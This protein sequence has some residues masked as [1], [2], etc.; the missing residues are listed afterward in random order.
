MAARKEIL[1]FI[2]QEQT[3]TPPKWQEVEAYALRILEA[4]NERRADTLTLQNDLFELVASCKMCEQRGIKDATPNFEVAVMLLLQTALDWNICLPESE[5]K[6]Y[7]N[8]KLFI[9]DNLAKY[10]METYSHQELRHGLPPAECP[11]ELKDLFNKRKDAEP[12]FR[13]YYGMPGQ[14]VAE[15]YI[16]RADV[17]PPNIGEKGPMPVGKILFDIFVKPLKGTS[18]YC[19]PSTFYRHLKDR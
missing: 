12:F 17:I 18:G 10:I 19:D 6:R 15:A 3:T 8:V 14:Y 9:I 5:I 4:Y 2:I 1:D 11:K 16:G 13:Q 7:E